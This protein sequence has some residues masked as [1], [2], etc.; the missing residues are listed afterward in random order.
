MAAGP[1]APAEHRLE[2]VEAVT[3]R[4]E[5]AP[6]EREADFVDLP[7]TRARRRPELRRRLTEQNHP[8]SWH[9][10][11]D[12]RAS[13]YLLSCCRLRDREVEFFLDQHP[14]APTSA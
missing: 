6:T 4:V 5:L 3:M 12:R 2:K 7:P 8:E 9:G 13:S 11:D 10:S 1:R 14:Q